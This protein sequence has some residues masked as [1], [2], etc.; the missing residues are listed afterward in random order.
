M[1]AEWPMSDYLGA[2][3]LKSGTRCPRMLPVNSNFIVEL[4]LQYELKGLAQQ[5][6]HEPLIQVWPTFI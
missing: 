5:I 4:G 3:P 6:F 2:G 1:N